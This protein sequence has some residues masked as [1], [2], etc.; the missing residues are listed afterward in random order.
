MLAAPT[1]ASAETVV[2]EGNHRVDAETIRSYFAGG[3]SN[4]AVKKL[5]NTG[6][7]SD[8][9]VSRRGGALVVR[10]TENSSSINHVVFVGNSKMKS[11]DL[12]KEVQSNDRGAY[13]KAMVDSDVLRIQDVYR[14]SGRNTATVSARTVE[15]PNGTVD[16][17]FDINEGEKTGIKEIRFVGNSA[18][19]DLDTAGADGNDGD[20]L[21]VVPQNIRRLRS[22][23]HRQGRRGDPSLLSEE[24]L[25]RFPRHRHRRGL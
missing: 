22:R 15:T 13:S 1:S 3:D 9:Q 11:E 21:S 14:R 16:V 19:F 7:F 17:V 25:R 23:P 8:V 24:R 10:V 5:Y 12:Q 18:Y 6:Y 20:E 4:E 2:V